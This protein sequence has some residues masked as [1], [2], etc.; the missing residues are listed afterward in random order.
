MDKLIISF[1]T[2]L[3]SLAISAF[4]F[5]IS[6]NNI[7]FEKKLLTWLH[8]RYFRPGYYEF[9]IFRIVGGRLLDMSWCY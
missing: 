8:V 4:W 6:I 7:I 9:H 5:D 1:F 3:Q 2:H